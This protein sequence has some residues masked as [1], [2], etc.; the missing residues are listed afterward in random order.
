M[1][2]LVL[3]FLLTLTL[4][5]KDARLNNHPDAKEWEKVANTQSFA[6]YNLGRTYHVK[7]KDYDK[8]IFWYKKAYELDNKNTDAA[9][10]LGLLYKDLKQNENA[11]TWYKKASAHS[12]AD[13]LINLA[14]L[15][16]KAY[17]S[18]EIKGAYGLG[19]LYDVDKKDSVNAII[20]YKKAA[21]KGYADAITNLGKVYHSQGDKVTGSAYTIAMINYGYTKKQVFREENPK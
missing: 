7:I 3:L 10:N 12:D 21:K 5:A 8:A 9:N 17:E 11:V 19:Y 16:K 4:F 20:W 15:Y 2:Q 14:L 18:G 13:A 1:R 6:A